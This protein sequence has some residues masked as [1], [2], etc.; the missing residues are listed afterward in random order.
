MDIVPE[1]PSQLNLFEHSNPKHRALM[2]VIDRVNADFGPHKIMLAA[3][4]PARR[5]KMRQEKLSPR[6][7]TKLEDIITIKTD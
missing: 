3:Q 2:K 4:D 6:Y 5:W 1:R 7:T